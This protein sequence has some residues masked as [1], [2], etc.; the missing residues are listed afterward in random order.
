MQQAST[1]QNQAQMTPAPAPRMT[2]LVFGQ[3]RDYTWY[4]P[5]GDGTPRTAQRI[6]GWA[7]G[8]KQRSGAV[9]YMAPG[10]DAERV[11]VWIPGHLARLRPGAHFV[12]PQDWLDPVD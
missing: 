3:R 11:A 7:C 4:G 2:G 9:L 1:G 5:V 10:E 6:A 12:R 8:R